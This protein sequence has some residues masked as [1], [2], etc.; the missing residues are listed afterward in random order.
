MKKNKFSQKLSL[1]KNVVSNLKSNTVVGGGPTW[2]NSCPFTCAS[3]NARHAPCPAPVETDTCAPSVGC[4]PPTI[5]NCPTL[6][7]TC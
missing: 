2:Q 5:Q 3:I 7:V 6:Y 4:E 1:G